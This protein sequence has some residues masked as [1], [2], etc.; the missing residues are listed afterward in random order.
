MTAR[1]HHES[2][3]PVP[4]RYV[5]ASRPDRGPAMVE[6]IDRRLC[7]DCGNWYWTGD[8]HTCPPR[9]QVTAAYIAP[10]VADPSTIPDPDRAH[11]ASLT[12]HVPQ[13]PRPIMPGSGAD[14]PVLH[15][16][17]HLD[18]GRYWA[19][20]KHGLAVGRSRIVMDAAA[21]RYALSALLDR[22]PHLAIALAA[23]ANRWVH[24]STAYAEEFAS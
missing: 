3:L 12:W 2:S 13:R 15:P 20:A 14:G 22:S 23:A 16:A 11:P 5:P 19:G 4:L 17:L 7:R 8:E 18:A 10:A 9:D 6:H 24:A 21:V 1:Q